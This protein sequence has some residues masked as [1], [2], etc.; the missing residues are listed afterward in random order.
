MSIKH[1]YI[2][3]DTNDGDY[4]GK[5]IKVKDELAE[6]FKPLIEKISQFK[7]YKTTTRYDLTWNHTSN[8]LYGECLRKDLG[9]KHPCE[10]YNI[11]REIYEE[12]IETFSL[13]GGEWG[14]HTITRIQEINLGKIWL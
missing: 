1:F 14:F 10:L 3:V 5:I 9:E 13:Y 11:N 7:P 8:F 4:I 12:F 2:E 6:K